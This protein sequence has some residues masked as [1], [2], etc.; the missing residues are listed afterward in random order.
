M[1]FGIHMPLKKG[2]AYNARRLKEIGGETI[3][4][5]P[6]NPSSWKP[7][8]TSPE[9][10][11][12]RADLL[13]ELEIYPL[14][15]HTAYLI[16]MATP[17]EDVFEKSVKLMGETLRQASYYRAPYVVVH[18]GS[19]GGDGL[20]KGMARIKEALE[21]LEPAWP[22][23]VK[24]LLENTAGEGNNLGGKLGEIGSIL[25]ENS[26][27]PL[28]FCLDTA[29]AWGAGYDFSS[30]EGVSQIMA[31]IENEVGF[32]NLQV[33]HANDTFVEKGSRKD[34]HEH[35]G[36]GQIGLEGFKRLFKYPWPEDFPVILETPEIG[37]EKDQENLETLRG[38]LRN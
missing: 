1:R 30:D 3:Q 35:I 13:D 8:A 9:E 20:Q 11:K 25:Q 16:N 36:E 14:V 38:C 5:F 2:F 29:H 12:E 4:I 32:D 17:K 18:T 15:I 19:H 24:L 7:P 28:G 27:L 23:G 21:Q 26:H 6:G 34:R 22:E 33:I 37:T 31:E 10:L